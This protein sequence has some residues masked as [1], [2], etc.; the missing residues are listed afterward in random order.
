MN[1]LIK[2]FYALLALV[3]VLCF[4]G[5]KKKGKQVELKQGISVVT[6]IFP[7]FDWIREIVKGSENIKLSLL[8]DS[9]TDM[10][11]FQ[12]TSDDIVKLASCDMFVY[13]GGESE[14]WVE[15]AIKESGNRDM[16]VVNLLDVLGKMSKEEEVVEG[17]EEHIH[18]HEHSHS[19][20]SEHSSDEIEYDE[21]IWLSLKNAKFLCAKIT[22]TLCTVDSGNRV[23]YESNLREYVSK[24]DNLDA[25][26]EK[27]VKN[28]PKHTV[29]F[30]D[31]FPF[32]YLMD[33]YGLGYYAAFPGCSAESEASF[34]TIIFLSKKL[35][36]LAL[37]CVLK[38]E[39]S[40]KK[41]ASK[42]IENSKEKN[43]KIATM[44]SMQSVTKKDIENG[45]YY[46]GIMISNL[47]VLA[48][49]LL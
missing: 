25:E 31:R 10:H 29:L 3:L 38:I 5:C 45:I 41:I 40:D 42:I 22:E 36:E 8:L 44:N 28:S 34:D 43:R 17:M 24:I 39:G 18:D 32:R 27:V 14:R 15:K 4:A 12:P 47:G 49:V 19:D 2:S 35:D 46:I 37:G 16:V 6:T 1:K 21:H 11:N 7:E 13:I 20:D 48:E 30:G 23:L 9:G 26:Y 33:D